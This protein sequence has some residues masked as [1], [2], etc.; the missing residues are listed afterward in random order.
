MPHTILVENVNWVYTTTYRCHIE[1]LKKRLTGIFLITQVVK[2]RV[3]MLNRSNKCCKLIKIGSNGFQHGKG[4]RNCAHCGWGRI[5]I[6]LSK[7]LIC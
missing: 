4:N 6:V 1:L 3:Y 7:R 2:N 5:M